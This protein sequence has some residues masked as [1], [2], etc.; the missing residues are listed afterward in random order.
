MNI[1]KSHYL[2]AALIASPLSYSE[3]MSHD[4]ISLTYAEAG[5]DDLDI[6]GILIEG[7]KTITEN[8]FISAGLA[9]AKDKDGLPSGYSL[10]G[11][12]IGLGVFANM[13]L[14]S[15]FEIYG[16]LEVNRTKTELDTSTGNVSDT[17][18]HKDLTFGVNLSTNEFYQAGLVLSRDIGED[19]NE[20]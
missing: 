4:N 9:K 17:D 2:L 11:T 20:N 8:F 10:D 1:R 3:P 12:I 19:E 13:D 7:E 6:S 15:S 14:N 16:G 18:T 5:D